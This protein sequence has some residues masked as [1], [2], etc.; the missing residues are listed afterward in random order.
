[1]DV[2]LLQVL[3]TANIKDVMNL[4]GQTNGIPKAVE[5]DIINYTV[6]LGKKLYFRAYASGGDADGLFKLKINGA[7]INT[8]RNSG[9]MRSVQVSIWKDG[10]EL[11]ISA[12]GIVR[13]TVEHSEKS[14]MSFEGNILGFMVNM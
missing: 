3:P 6:P 9:A 2:K 8:M 13:L 12:G 7:V 14:L 11:P 10:C 4:S 5:A 1:M